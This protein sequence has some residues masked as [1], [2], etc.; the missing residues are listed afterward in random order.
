MRDF[1]EFANSVQGTPFKNKGRDT[2]GWDC[3]G[4]VVCTYRECFGIILLDYQQEYEDALKAKEVAE[5]YE[6]HKHLWKQLQPGEERAGDVV[7]LRYGSWPCHVAVVATPGKMLHVERGISTCIEHYNSL[8]W[9]KK[10]IG[11]FRHA[12]RN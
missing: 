7:V 9:K 3:W 5:A 12:E 4:L 8:T 11:F 2:S 1:T 10:I 6:K